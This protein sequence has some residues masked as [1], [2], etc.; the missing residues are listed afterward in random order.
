MNCPLSANLCDCDAGRSLIVLCAHNASTP[1]TP[2]DLLRP[3]A[4]IS[5]RRLFQTGFFMQ[6]LGQIL[7]L[8]AMLLIA[9]S[10][11]VAPAKPAPEPRILPPMAATEVPVAN[12]PVS[13][14]PFN[15]VD[16]RGSGSC[17]NAS[18][19]FNLH[20]SNQPQLADW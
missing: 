16:S 19:V 15:W 8:P 5:D 12:L 18:T 10:G 2:P 4:D 3:T 20:W 11:C 6:R 17:V 9:L 14:R 13:L 7:L 1:A